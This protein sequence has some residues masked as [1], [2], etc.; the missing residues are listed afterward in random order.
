MNH[1][2]RGLT[3]SQVEDIR[4]KA[5][6]ELSARKNASETLGSGAMQA[7]TPGRAINQKSASDYYAER[8]HHI[9]TY[10]DNPEAIPHYVE[11]REAAETFAKVIIRHAGMSPDTQRAIEYVRAAVMFANASIALEGRSL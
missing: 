4:D 5:N 1:E 8:L 11:I 2:F 7:K 3:T 6:K 10:H 9:F